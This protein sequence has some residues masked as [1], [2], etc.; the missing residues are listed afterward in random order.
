MTHA[1]RKA[2]RD[3]EDEAQ[4]RKR[5]QED[6]DEP[7][8]LVW[9]VQ[10]NL[11]WGRNGHRFVARLSDAGHYS[12]EGAIALAISMIPRQDAHAS[13]LTDIPVRLTDVELIR[14]TFRNQFPDN[15]SEI[16]E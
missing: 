5:A 10:K 3:D 7:V 14:A 4:R 2:L 15:P 11:W 8:Y 13:M 12:R 6:R 16:W 9:S 1:S